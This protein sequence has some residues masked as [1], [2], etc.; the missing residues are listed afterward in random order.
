[1]SLLLAAFVF[2]LGTGRARARRLVGVKTGELRHQALHDALTGLPNRALIIDRIEQLLAR[3]R[4]T[5]TAGAVLFVDL[6][7]FKN[8]NDTLGHEAG[9][10]LLRGGRRSD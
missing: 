4:R 6:D 9:D 8:V 10:Q 2:V 7:E 3:S 1:M 5:G